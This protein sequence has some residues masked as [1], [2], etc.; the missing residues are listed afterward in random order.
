V[1]DLSQGGL[2]AA[3]A[4]LAPHATVKLSG[5]PYEQLFSETYGRF[6][7]AFTHESALKGLGYSV[8]GEVGGAS[9]KITAGTKTFSISDKE[10]NTALS[11]LSTLMRQSKH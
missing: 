2:L 11:S 4:D 9:L 3:L 7:I 10:M 6:L 1:T 8:I 5:D